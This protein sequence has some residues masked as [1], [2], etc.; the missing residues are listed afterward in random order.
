MYI[1]YSNCDP[2]MKKL[3]QQKFDRGRCC[4]CWAFVVIIKLGLVLRATCSVTL[5]NLWRQLFHF[6][7]SLIHNGCT[8]ICSCLFVFLKSKTG[9]ENF[10]CLFL[11]LGKILLKQTKMKT[12]VLQTIA[13]S[14]YTLSLVFGMYLWWKY[15]DSLN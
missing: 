8:T 15:F 4:W 14:E 10:I 1:W 6:I 11:C 12:N 2:A 5:L 13:K 9:S 7:L 3:L